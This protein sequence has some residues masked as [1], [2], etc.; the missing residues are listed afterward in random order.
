M[1]ALARMRLEEL[2]LTNCQVRLGDVR[3]LPLKSASAD[4]IIIHQLL[5]FLDDPAAAI[6]EAARILAPNGL[7]MVVDFAPHEIET[8][9]ENHEHRRLGFS[10][11][12]ILRIFDDVDIMSYDYVHLDKRGTKLSPSNS[13]TVTIWSGVKSNIAVLKPD[14]HSK[15]LSKKQKKSI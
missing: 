7:L 4:L 13:L 14:I 10:Q 1:L 5:H 11:D 9:R 2:S 3:L 8:L 6:S 15:Q 12:E